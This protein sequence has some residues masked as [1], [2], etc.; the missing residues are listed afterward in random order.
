MV[1]FRMTLI[2][3]AVQLDRSI[4]AYPEAGG[5]SNVRSLSDL[6]N[7]SERMADRGQIFGNLQA[8]SGSIRQEFPEIWTDLPFSQQIHS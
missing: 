7:R 4:E 3:F 8:N 2:S 5:K 1:I 6:G